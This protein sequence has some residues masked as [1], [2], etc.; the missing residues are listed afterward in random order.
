MV[1]EKNADAYIVAEVWQDLDTYAK[2]YES[3]IDS[4][5]DFAFANADGID[6]RQFK[7]DRRL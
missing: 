1:E 2:Y 6:C 3:G 4:C 7:E 5:F